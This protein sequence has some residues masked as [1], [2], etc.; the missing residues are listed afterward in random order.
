MRLSIHHTHAG[1]F[2]IDFPALDNLVN[3]LRENQQQQIDAFTKSIEG[4]TVRLKRVTDI[5]RAAVTEE[6][7]T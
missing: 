6:Q 5:L 1:N 2:R 3:F 7:N 4:S